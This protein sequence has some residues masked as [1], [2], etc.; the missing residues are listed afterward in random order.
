MASLALEKFR[1][2]VSGEQ[3]ALERAVRASGIEVRDPTGATKSISPYSQVN[4]TMVSEWDAEQAV[5]LAYYSNVFVY[6]CIHQCAMAIAGL[7]FRAGMNPDKPDI[8]NAQ[9]P[10]AIKLGPPPYGP[11][12]KISA[13]RLWAWTVAQYLITGKVGWELELPKGVSPASSEAATS[14]IVNMWPLVSCALFATPTTSGGAYFKGFTYGKPS[15]NP[16]DLTPYQPSQVFYAWRPSAHDYRQPESPLQAARLAVS[17]AVMQDRYDYA[18]LRNDARPAAIVVHEAFALDAEK[19]AFKRQFRGEYRGPD[20]AGKAMFVEA[21]GDGKD[22]VAG[23]LDV[24]VLG[25]TQKDAQFIQR[26]SQKINEICVA[27]G[28]P[29]SILGDGSQRTY[30]NANVEHRNWWE[31]TLQPLCSELADEVNMQVAPR[32]GPEV[33]W[34]DF[35]NVRA[36]QS[37]SRLLALGPILPLIVGPGLPIAASEFRSELGLPEQRPTDSNDDTL[38]ADKE[39]YGVGGKGEPAPPPVP[40]LPSST[41]SAAAGTAD[42]GA[43]TPVP[44][45]AGEPNP[46]QARGAGRQMEM[47]ASTREARAAEWRTVDAKVT[48]LESPF[49]SAM[50]KIFERQAR[51]VASKMSSRRGR[52]LEQRGVEADD[53]FDSEFWTQETASAIE[54]QY[55]GVTAAAIDHV[56]QRMNVTYTDDNG[57][58]R[59]FNVQDPKAQEFIQ[60]RANQLAGQVSDTTY[61]SIKDALAAGV[62]EGKAIPDLA[63]AV[64]HVFDVASDSRAT[65]IARTEVISAFN[66]STAMVGAALPDD[67]AAGQ[68]WIATD[69]DRTRE[70]HADA[71]GQQV[72]TG[73]QFTVGDDQLDYPGDP[74][75]SEENTINCRCTVGLLTPEQMGGGS[76]NSSDSADD[77]A[78]R[79]NPDL[80]IRQ[81]VDAMWYTDGLGSVADEATA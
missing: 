25:A 57:H 2:V 36:L 3:R 66:G 50:S 21:S 79:A 45:P 62:A 60:Q 27:L 11:A 53:L 9:A 12:P 73:A 39:K 19:E 44:A 10:L 30:D 67:V 64:Q 6:R 80:E 23:A 37:D 20:N 77:D 40:G 47:R 81:L 76:G 33:G 65:T 42:G 78:N 72:A 61:N 31:G 7:P 15:A 1:S 32:M 29:L 18:F 17:V 70:A 59:I 54:D 5:R 46:T 49:A 13:R 22:G 69:D 63:D 24:K 58:D 75:G 35:S 14:T 48:N 71:D 43:P 55:A 52:R 28:T 56:A 26:Y 68:E 16:N 34:F 4:S 74:S 38:T 41:P 8:F 51:S